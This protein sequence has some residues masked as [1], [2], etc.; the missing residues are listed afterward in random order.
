MM[1]IDNSEYMRNGDYAPTRFDAMVDALNIVFQ[2]KTDTNP[3]N[4][5]GLM[6]LAGR[7]P[8]VLVTHTRELG[9]VIAGAHLTRNKIS[10]AVDIATAVNVAQLALKHRQNK[11]LRQRIVL[12]LGSPLEGPNDDEKNLVKLAKR[13]KKNNIAV[14]IV[15]FG[16]G[17]EEGET[18]VLKTF[19]DN[20]NSSDNS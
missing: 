10:G 12:F 9:Q 19:I 13:L 4:T 6:T 11:N 18:S 17:I 5:V 2:T 3:E 8:E 1:V 7:G 14:D 15:A 20:V 16:D